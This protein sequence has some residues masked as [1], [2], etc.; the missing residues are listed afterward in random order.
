M[1]VSS[2]SARVSATAA[3]TADV[4]D[5]CKLQDSRFEAV[6]DKITAMYILVRELISGNW[7]RNGSHLLIRSQ[8]FRVGTSTSKLN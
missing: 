4:P 2:L 3:A 1:A 5:A 8:F 6:Q 7:I